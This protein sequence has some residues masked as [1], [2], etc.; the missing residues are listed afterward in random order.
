MRQLQPV[1]WSKGVFLSPQHLQAQDRFFEDS[2]RFTIESLSFRGWG[3]STLQIESASI[4]EGQLQIGVASGLFPDGL[5]FDIGGTDVAPHS[6]ILDECF[7]EGGSACTFFLAIPQ[8]RRGGVNIAPERTG[9]A[10]RFYSELQ[11]F[12]DENSSGQ[13]KPVSL[14][15]RNLQIV[16]EGENMEGLI[17]L[18][19]ARVVKTEAGRYA[20][21]PEFISPALN[22]RANERL[23]TIL[24]GLLEVLVSRSSQLTGVRRQRNQSLADFSASDVANFWLLYTINTHLPVFQQMMQSPHVHPETLYSQM[25]ALCGALTTFSRDISPLDLPRY[26]HEKLGSCFQQLELQL[27]S[28]LNTV[29][30]SRFTSLPLRQVRESVYATDIERDEY[31]ASFRFYLAIAAEI[32]AADLIAR[33]PSLV[34]VCSATH[35][36]TLIRQALPGVPMTHLPSPPPEIPVKLHYQ[37]FSL[38]RAG[39]AWEAIRRARNFG[40]YVPGEISNPRM[41]LLLIPTEPESVHQNP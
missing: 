23:M 8:T 1:V 4:S 16:A 26:E 19:L 35:L 25:L 9:L 3:F 17:T 21:D 37:Y 2:L 34:K 40:V 41:E 18:P 12:R 38:D 39:A 31:L 24:R 33:T 7:R 5:A 14:A 13:E 22:I 29:I 28:L 11:I 27:I 30:P 6:R 20:L 10:T 36:D 32:P 15:R